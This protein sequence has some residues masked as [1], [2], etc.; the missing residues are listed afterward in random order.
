MAHIRGRTVNNSHLRNPQ[1]TAAAGV[2]S[3]HCEL[4]LT[5][6]VFFC[7]SDILCGP[8]HGNSL[9]KLGGDGF[10]IRSSVSGIWLGCLEEVRRWTRTNDVRATKDVHI[11]TVAA[12]LIRGQRSSGSQSESVVQPPRIAGPART[13][14]RVQEHRPRRTKHRISL[15]PS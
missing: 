3:G 13:D 1:F 2:G 10:T 9:E 6:L 15:R 5:R 7:A 14:D 4:T 12:V 8:R 11:R